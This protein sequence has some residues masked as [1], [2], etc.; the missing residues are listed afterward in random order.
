MKLSTALCVSFLCLPLLGGCQSSSPQDESRDQAQAYVE[1]E[2]QP[3]SSLVALIRVLETIDALRDPQVEVRIRALECDTLLSRNQKPAHVRVVLDLTLY[4][5]DYALA[6]EARAALLAG[7]Q[8]EGLAKTRLRQVGAP[9]IQRVFEEMAWNAP[10]VHS[11]R[12]FAGLVSVSE[13][14]RVDIFESSAGSAVSVQP[15][16][17]MLQ[18]SNVPDYIKATANLPDSDLGP[19]DTELSPHRLR[20]DRTDLRYRI[21]PEY[22]EDSYGRNRIGAFLYNLEAGSPGVRITHLAIAPSDPGED[23]KYDLWSFEADLTLRI[24]G[25]P[26]GR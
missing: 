12:D 20:D 2:D 13:S 14:L 9:R 8:E 11:E 22:Q 1:L 5:S 17:R 24:S 15:S 19:L 23:I 3:Q 21:R 25:T 10:R 16:E 6:D 26:Q 7:L 4:A 18:S